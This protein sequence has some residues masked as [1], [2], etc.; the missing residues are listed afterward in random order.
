[1]SSKAPRLTAKQAIKQLKAVGF[2]EVSQ[3]GSHLTVGSL[4]FT[5]ENYFLNEGMGHPAFVD[6]YASRLTFEEFYA[7]ANF[8]API[9]N[10]FNKVGEVVQ[11]NYFSA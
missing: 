8:S 2:V 6:F 11:K 9:E 7:S 10:I 4:N 3:T 1:M 5:R